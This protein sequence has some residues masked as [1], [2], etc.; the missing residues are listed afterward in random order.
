MSLITVEEA[1]DHLRLTFEL[2]SPP[3]QRERDLTE[4]IAAAEAIVIDYIG[5]TE[6]WRDA[7][8]EWYGSPDAL[9]YVV[10]AAILLQLGELYRFRGDEVDGQGPA[11]TEGHLS[12]VVTNLLRRYRDPVI[13]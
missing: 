12:P 6:H 5:S 3:S 4:K 11:H 10:K 9:P 8:Q 1:M 7:L 13:S 2:T